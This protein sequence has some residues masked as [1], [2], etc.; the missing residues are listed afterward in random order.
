VTKRL[1]LAKS[2]SAS[3]ELLLAD[4]SALA[5]VVTHLVR[6]Q[7][8]Q[9][10]CN[11]QVVKW[12]AMLAAFSYSGTQRLFEQQRRLQGQLMA[13]RAALAAL[14]SQ[15]DDQDVQLQNL[16]QETHSTRQELVRVQAEIQLRLDEQAGTLLIQARQVRQLTTDK[17]K[18]GALMEGLVLGL[19]AMASKSVLVDM[20]ISVLTLP[21]RQGR[22]KSRV[23]STLRLASFFLLAHKLRKQALAA[24]LVS[25][26][27]SYWEVLSV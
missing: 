17:L 27:V 21:L 8:Q 22:L 14:R 5:Q 4:P 3:T 13:G 9:E 11:K 25:D 23:C 7:A 16:Q 2:A 12:S 10:Q 18:R 19:A 1:M 15:V 20:P 26:D 24:G 6:R